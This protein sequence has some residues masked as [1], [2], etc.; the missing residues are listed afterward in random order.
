MFGLGG[1]TSMPPEREVQAT[2]E[3]TTEASVRVRRETSISST[4][5]RRER[6]GQQQQKKSAQ[7]GPPFQVPDQRR[8]AS[9]MLRFWRVMAG[10]VARACARRVRMYSRLTGSAA[11][12]GLGWDELGRARGHEIELIAELTAAFLCAHLNITGE[13]RH[14]DY[15]GHW[16]NLLKSD[17]RAVFTAANK[18]SQAADYLRAFSEKLRE[19]A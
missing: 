7:R 8:G 6:E 11:G 13:L 15:I 1:V 9:S 14:A 12:R 17:N 16:L 5:Q 10:M 2:A 19:A 18:A 4:F 3:R